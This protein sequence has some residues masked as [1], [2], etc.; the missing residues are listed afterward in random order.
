MVVPI[1]QVSNP[2]PQGCHYN[3]QMPNTLG[4]GMML[5][6]CTGASWQCIWESSLMSLDGTQAHTLISQCYFPVQRD[7]GIAQDSSFLPTFLH[8]SR[9]KFF[10]TQRKQVNELTGT[11]GSTDDNGYING[12]LTDE[13]FSLKNQIF[14]IWVKVTKSLGFFLKIGNTL[15]DCVVSSHMLFLYFQ[16]ISVMSI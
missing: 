9:R 4:S 14:G 5:L 3:I 12:F 2:Q 1:T 6:A 10:F 11:Q 13:I 8:P 7:H 15:R 16:R